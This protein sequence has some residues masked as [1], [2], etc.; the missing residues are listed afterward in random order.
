M[1]RGFFWKAFAERKILRCGSLLH[2]R[3]LRAYAKGHP[4]LAE[5]AF[6]PQ[7]NEGVLAGGGLGSYMLTDP[8]R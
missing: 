4:P 8:G 3:R 2:P 1:W 7:R 5:V 6:T